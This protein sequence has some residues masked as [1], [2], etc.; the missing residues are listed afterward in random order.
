MKKRM[1]IILAVLALLFVSGAIWIYFGNT[2][3]GTTHYTLES[4][5]LPDAFDGFTIAQVSDLH[6]TEFGE[7]NERLLS[8]LRAAAP[9]IIV[10]T[11]DVIDSRHTDVE[12]A[13]SFAASA[14]KIAPVYYVTGNHESRVPAEAAALEKKMQAAG[15]QILHNKRVRISRGD[16]SID[17]LGIDDPSVGAEEDLIG[18]RLAS[19]TDHTRFTV[20][21][22][23]R[24][25]LFNTYCGAGVDLVLSG[26][27]HGGQLRLPLLGGVFAPNQG[28]FPQYTEGSHTCK[29]TTM[30]VSRGLGNSLFPFRVN[31]P[32]EL[33]VVCLR[34]ETTLRTFD[35]G[36]TVMAK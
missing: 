14:V 28:F 12:I 2:R 22:S 7:D 6:N 3:I 25:D 24:P 18:A 4:A 35:I 9:D 27:A 36:K 8:A 32:P 26:H 21:L 23:H 17:L 29:G 5:R 16:E 33:V 30:I 20:L 19:L 31:D 15:I 1:K 10:I 11:G 34:T 13:A